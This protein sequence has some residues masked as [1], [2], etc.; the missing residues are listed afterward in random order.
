MKLQTS[1]QFDQLSSNPGSPVEGE[2]WY[3]VTDGRLRLRRG[4]N[5]VDLDPTAKPDE[6]TIAQNE[7]VNGTVGTLILGAFSFNTADW[8]SGAEFEF[9]C[10]IATSNSGKTAEAKLY[11]LTNS[12]FVTFSS[13]CSTTSTTPEEKTSG[14]LTVGSS[15]GNLRNTDTVYEVRVSTTSTA[16][17]DVTV[18]G[19]A[20]I[21][22]S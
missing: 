19:R 6:L 7:E 21:K 8:P 22:V 1:V 11:N 5:V 10:V 2:V 9:G 17:A 16:Q 18:L 15:S 3:N 14:T 12:E 20:W 4:S 13:A